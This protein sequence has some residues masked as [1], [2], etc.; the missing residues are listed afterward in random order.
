MMMM[1]MMMIMMLSMVKTK[2]MQNEER[3]I[4]ATKTEETKQQRRA[5]TPVVVQLPVRSSGDGER[6]AE[7]KK[8][9]RS[10]G[11]TS[12]A[13]RMVTP[14]RVGLGIQSRKGR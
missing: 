4:V 5:T 1:M 14:S 12:Q 9:R 8:S 11:E 10:E 7:M 13:F 6:V 3:N 2:E